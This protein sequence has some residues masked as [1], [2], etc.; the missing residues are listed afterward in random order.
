MERA[1]CSRREAHRRQI[2]KPECARQRA[3][4]AQCNRPG[5]QRA[6]F[7][8]HDLQLLAVEIDRYAVEAPKGIHAE[9]KRRLAVE[10]KP[11]ERVR[12]REDDRKLLERD[13]A[14]GELSNDRI[15]ADKLLSGHGLQLDQACT[16]HAP[17]AELPPERRIPDGNLR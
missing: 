6:L 4:S 15:L 8:K 17:P 13:A 1:A 5:L 10:A 7:G 16:L 3:A 2:G 12:V 11:L 14:H 9:K